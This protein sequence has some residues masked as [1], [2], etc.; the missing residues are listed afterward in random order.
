MS[1]KEFIKSGDL[2]DAYLGKHALELTARTSE[3]MQRVYDSRGLNFPIEVSSVLHFLNANDGA[4]VTEIAAGLDIPHQL[5]A[6]RIRKLLAFALVE[7]SQDPHDARRTA[8]NLTRKGREASEGLIACME[9]T[10]VIYR[11]L[12]AEIGCD[13]T[14]ALGR[15]INA[16]EQRSLIERFEARFSKEED[17]A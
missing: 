13:L 8:L 14:A 6:Q 3:Q 10:A 9:D 5:A 2:A 7:K 16:I 4:S 12:F 1:A 11:E 15:A 17:A